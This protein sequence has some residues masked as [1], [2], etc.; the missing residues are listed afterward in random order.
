MRHLWVGIDCG[1]SQMSAAVVDES[2]RV[3]AVERTREPPG[4]GHT[5]DVAL[6][7]LR[8]LLERLRGVRDK[9]GGPARLAGYC[10]DHSGVREAFEQEGWRV[11]GCTALNDVVGVY[12]LTAMQGNVVVFGCGSWSQVVYVD[13]ANTI[14]WPGEEIASAMPDWLPSGSA[15]ARFLVEYVSQTPGANTGLARVAAEKLGADPAAGAID[16]SA[17][18]WGELGPLLSSALDLPEVRRFLSQAAAAVRQTRDLFW[19]AVQAAR[20]AHGS[21]GLDVQPPG[22]VMGGGAVRDDRLWSVLQTELASRGVNATRV[23]G[24]HAVGLARFA[25]HNPG[26]NAWAYLGEKK[27]SWLS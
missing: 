6:A 10:Y 14:F 15:Y 4:D 12:G 2:G 3:L 21:H 24:E 23:V 8:R 17:G 22:V 20:A 16:G 7:R 1:F 13:P 19:E 5:R 9:S 25:R 27:P 26:A 18:R 11:E